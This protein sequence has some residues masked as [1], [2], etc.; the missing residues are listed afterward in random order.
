MKLICRDWGG[1]DDDC[2]EVVGVPEASEDN[3]NKASPLLLPVVAAG[4]ELGY[5]CCP[6]T[7]AIPPPKCEASWGV[8]FNVDTLTVS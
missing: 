8:D 3:N 5:G 4:M 7:A 1:D 6:V 2:G